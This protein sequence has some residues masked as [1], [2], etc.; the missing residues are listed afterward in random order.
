[1]EWF[2]PKQ[3]ITDSL[4]INAEKTLETWYAK[5]RIANIGSVLIVENPTGRPQMI[6]WGNISFE[7]DSVTYIYKIESTGEPIFLLAKVSNTCNALLSSTKI[8]I[9]YQG[10]LKD[11]GKRD[12]LPW[13]L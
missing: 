2:P 6:N 9:T 7:I 1:M 5:M 4:L 11:F 3:K 13:K 8:V 10:K 12:C